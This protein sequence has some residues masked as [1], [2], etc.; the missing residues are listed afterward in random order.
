MV[1]MALGLLET[2]E[3][4]EF[5]TGA[6]TDANVRAGAGPGAGTKWIIFI[7]SDTSIHPSSPRSLPF[8]PHVLPDLAAEQ[9]GSTAQPAHSLD[10]LDSLVLTD[11][12]RIDGKSSSEQQF[13]RTSPVI[14]GNVL[15]RFNGT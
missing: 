3:T 4:T 7:F 15:D 2:C 6:L 12:G 5:V 8:L 10:S 14:V 9:H 1:V 13:H 11:S